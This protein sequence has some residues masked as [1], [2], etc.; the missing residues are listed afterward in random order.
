[1]SVHACYFSQQNAIQYIFFWSFVKITT[2]QEC[3]K[4]F[5]C[6][7]PI[8]DVL[9]F[10]VSGVY[11]WSGKKTNWHIWD[12]IEIWGLLFVTSNESTFLCIYFAP[13]LSYLYFTII[14]KIMFKKKKSYIRDEESN[15]EIYSHNYALNYDWMAGNRIFYNFMLLKELM[16]NSVRRNNLLYSVVLYGGQMFLYNL[17]LL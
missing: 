4:M 11:S 8:T 13:S 2:W 17:Q 10:A 15:F 9:F 1:M 3:F 5:L 14:C 12:L 7:C 16:L 6:S